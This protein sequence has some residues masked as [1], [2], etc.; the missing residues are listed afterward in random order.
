MKCFVCFR[1]WVVPVLPT[2]DKCWLPNTWSWIIFGKSSWWRCL[3]LQ[4]ML[5]CRQRAAAPTPCRG[6]FLVGTAAAPEQLS[7][8][9]S[10]LFQWPDVTSI[11]SASLLKWGRSVCRAAGG[12]AT[13][14]LAAWAAAELHRDWMGYSFWLPPENRQW[15]L[16]CC[17]QHGG[18]HIIAEMKRAVAIFRNVTPNTMFNL[19]LQRWFWNSS[20]WRDWCFPEAPAGLCYL[21]VLSQHTTAR[22]TVSIRWNSAKRKH[23]LS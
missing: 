6:A 3:H 9:C 8:V 4:S 23:F 18:L 15:Q 1:N 2:R 14:G 17:L 11:N 19:L 13:R 10:W 21:L 5:L 7:F 20:G 16:L 12:P 22:K